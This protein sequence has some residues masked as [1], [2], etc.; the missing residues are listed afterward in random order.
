MKTIILILLLLISIT[1]GVGQ[2]RYTTGK[3]IWISE[4]VKGNTL[5]MDTTRRT[6]LTDSFRK[7]DSAFWVN[8]RNIGVY[9]NPTLLIDTTADCYYTFYKL[10]PEQK[11]RYIMDHILSDDNREITFTVREAQLLYFAGYVDGLID[12]D[13]RTPVNLRTIERRIAEQ[14]IVIER[15]VRFHQLMEGKLQKPLQ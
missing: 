13:K 11:Y 12:F 3:R 2:I 8:G 6:R 15:Q 9:R 7:A 1:Y 4:N 5:S 10:S 14:R